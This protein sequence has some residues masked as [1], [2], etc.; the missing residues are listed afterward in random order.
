M[1]KITSLILALVMAL[2]LTVTALADEPVIIKGDAAAFGAATKTWN[3]TVPAGFDGTKAPTKEA[4]V[5][6]TYYV[7]IEWSFDGTNTLKYVDNKANYS[8]KVLGAGD[9]DDTTTETDP[10]HA[11]YA[12]SQQWEGTAKINVTVTNWSNRAMKADME[13][14]P[15][16]TV[17]SGETTGVTKAIKVDET[18]CLTWVGYDGAVATP[19]AGIIVNS[20]ANGVPFANDTNAVTAGV[21]GS[22]SLT[23]DG[24]KLGGAI[25]ANDTVIGTLTITLVEK[26]A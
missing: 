9:A 6:A 15:V 12:V 4:D 8:W 5:T 1:K 23:I 7:K 14:V 25:N 26:T 21:A 13:F 17:V 22:G 18:G 16:T 2:S 11:G 24:T 10:T 20:A 3:V 19:T